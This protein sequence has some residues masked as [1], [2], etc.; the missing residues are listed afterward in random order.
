VAPTRHPALLRATTSV[1]SKDYRSPAPVALTFDDG[2]DPVWTPLVLD[3]LAA[4]SASATFFVIAPRA[5][6]YPHLVSSMREGGHDVAFHCNEHARHDTMTPREIE[7]DLASGLPA[8]GKSIH[9]WRTPWGLVTP[10]T[11]EVAN[12]HHLAL[13]GWTADTQ[14]WR[15]DAPEEMIARVRGDITPGALILMH[16]GIGP[17]ATR[18][19]CANTV[20]LVAPLVALVRSCGL[21]PAKLDDLHHPLPQTNPDFQTGEPGIRRVRSV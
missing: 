17:G 5:A 19:G 12:R 2:P 3:A 20:A 9:Y 10:A 6:R 1:V 21:E 7:A 13:V 15:G 14:D 4:A 11:E 18:D 8:L 16:D